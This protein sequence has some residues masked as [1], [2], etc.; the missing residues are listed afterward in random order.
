MVIKLKFTFLLILFIIFGLILYNGTILNSIEKSN[1][2]AVISNAVIGN[3]N[4]P[5]SLKMYYTIENKSDQYNIPN[6]ILYNI[7]Y[8]ETRYKGPFDFGYNPYLESSAGAQGPM[9]VIT[10]YAHHHYEGERKLNN[11]DLRTNI[12]LNVDICC[13][14]LN[15]LYKKYGRW[16]LVLGYYH[17][18]RPVVDS[19]TKYILNNK[20]Y[21]NKWIRIN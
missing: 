20:D 10:R 5:V 4:I 17:T 15:V 14:K 13:K 11:Y 16:D 21:S 1:N 3:N 8:L 6:Y 19:Y 9:Q 18:G 7:A 12:E 2:S